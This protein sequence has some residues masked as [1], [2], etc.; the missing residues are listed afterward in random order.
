VVEPDCILNDFRRESVAFV[1]FRLC[2]EPN[3]GR[4][5]INLSVSF[6]S[7][8]LFSSQVRSGTKQVK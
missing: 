4:L 3:I 2:H 7:M 1:Y 5:G 6:D 8:S